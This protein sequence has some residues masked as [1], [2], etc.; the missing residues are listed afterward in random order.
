MENKEKYIDILKKPLLT[1]KITSLSEK[2]KGERERYAF[3][4]DKWA[5]KIQIAKAVERMYGVTVEAVNT[6]NYKGKN[7]KRYTKTAVI[8]G[9]TPSYKKA[10]VTVKEGDF[11]D[12][13]ADI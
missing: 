5:N 7:K 2:V 6:M 10:I 11:I 8:S 13:Y 4:V 1:E 12:L 9:K 3:V